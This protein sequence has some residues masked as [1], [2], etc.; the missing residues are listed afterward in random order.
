MHLH[1]YKRADRDRVT[2]PAN[3][4]RSVHGRPSGFYEVPRRQLTLHGPPSKMDDRPT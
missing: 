3:K 1:I 2:I 4:W